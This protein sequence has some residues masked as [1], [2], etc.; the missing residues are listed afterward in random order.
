[1]PISDRSRSRGSASASRDRYRGRGQCHSGSRSRSNGA[2]R[3]GSSPP[4]RGRETGRSPA[5]SPP[6]SSSR[7]RHGGARRQNLPIH[8]TRRGDAG[9]E[10]DRS[11][12]IAEIEEAK[13]KANGDATMQ[14]VLHLKEASGR[15]R[16]VRGRPRITREEAQ[17]DADEMKRAYVEGGA[18]ELRKIQTKQRLNTGSRPG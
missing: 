13:S 1:M 8:M 15:E 9:V 4:R 2:R 18:A 3:Q 12:P 10:G 14:A 5:R 11:E 17:R 7:D 16:L 6:R